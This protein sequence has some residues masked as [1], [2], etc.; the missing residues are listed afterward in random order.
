MITKGI[1]ALTETGV[2]RATL[3][4]R[5]GSTWL[6]SGCT[7]FGAIIVVLS[8]STSLVVLTMVGNDGDKMN[9]SKEKPS[10]VWFTSVKMEMSTCE[11]TKEERLGAQSQANPQCLR[12]T[13]KK[14]QQTTKQ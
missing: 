6:G 5:L 8:I 9:R 11:E 1:W 3:K 12:N 2:I 13:C 4:E 14:A 7:R 10:K